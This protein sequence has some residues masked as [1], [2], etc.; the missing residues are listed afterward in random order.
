VRDASP[1]RAVSHNEQGETTV[2]ARFLSF[3]RNILKFFTSL[4]GRLKK[5]KKE[6]EIKKKK[7]LQSLL[8]LLWTLHLC[9]ATAEPTLT[10]ARLGMLSSFAGE[11]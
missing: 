7:L 2:A 8:L 5:K 1:A 6:D 3:L 10:R 9:L 4:S 11:Q